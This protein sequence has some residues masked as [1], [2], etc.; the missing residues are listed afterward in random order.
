MGRAT[1]KLFAIALGALTLFTAGCTLMYASDA[2]KKQCKVDSD[3]NELAGEAGDFECKTSIC[4]SIENVQS[5]DAGTGDGATENRVA[6]QNA[7]DCGEGERCGFDGFCYEKWGCLDNDPDWADNVQQEFA[8]QA[9]LRSLQSPDDVTLLGSI[10]A[11]A[12]SAADPNCER[13]KVARGTASVTDDK[14]IKMPF[15]GVGKSGFVG[16][17]KVLAALPTDIPNAK[18]VLPGYFHFTSE[19]PLVSDVVSQDRAL[20][21]D[22]G[23]YG[24]LGALAGTSTD[25]SSG[26]N[27]FLIYDCGGQSAADVSIIPSSGVT[28]FR[29][30]PIQGE[31]TP[32]ID[33]RTT[34]TDDGVAILIN[35]PP[36]SQG[37]VLKDEKLG[38]VISD[39]FSFNVRGDAINYVQY[40]PRFSGLKAW[41]DQHERGKEREKAAR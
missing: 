27:V 29:F 13:P 19:N 5:R 17:I 2:D 4:V 33:G 23:T 15:T 35:I 34:T 26:T 9:T 41:L 22:K 28:G 11:E 21:I 6:C 24:L 3:C 30:I 32:I 1:T 39:T 16:V 36:G 25:S 10:S 38:R 40:Y 14:V 20:L 7:K 31:T 12:C 37:F 18:P 8:W